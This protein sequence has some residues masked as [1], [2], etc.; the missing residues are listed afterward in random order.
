MTK[1]GHKKIWLGDRMCNTCLK[2]ITGKLFDARITR[3]GTWATLCEPCFKRSGAGL[4]T[5]R[6]QEYTEQKNGQF[7]KTGG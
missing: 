1:Q 7:V 2:R 6:G 4:G 5:G 3:G